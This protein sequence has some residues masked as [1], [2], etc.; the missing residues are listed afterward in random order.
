[1]R[2]L[3]ASCLVAVVACVAAVACEKPT[4]CDLSARPALAVTA[5]DSISRALVPNAVIIA[6]ASAA[7]SASIVPDSASIGANVGA[8]PVPL[9]WVLGTYVLTVRAAGYETWTRS[10]VVTSTSGTCH[11][12]LPMAV[13]AEMQASP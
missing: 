4:V 9:G 3:R 8:Y 10:V 6:S 1:M 5:V 13:T 7:D 2:H 12:G 11:G